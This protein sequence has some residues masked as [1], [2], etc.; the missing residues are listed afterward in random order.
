MAVKAF[1]LYFGSNN[2]NN[3]NN[4]KVCITEPNL[5]SISTNVLMFSFLPYNNVHWSKTKA[6]AKI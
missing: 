5:K 4:N 3:N 1:E 6:S 2:N